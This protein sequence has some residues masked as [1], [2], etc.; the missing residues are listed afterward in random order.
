MKP[1]I[2]INIDD[3]DQVDALFDA[4]LRIRGERRLAEQTGSD[5]GKPIQAHID[6]LTNT[7]RQIRSA[8]DIHH[9]DEA[10]ADYERERN[11]GWSVR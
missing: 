10:Q 7:V 1:A 3:P 11:E 8:D 5:P 9:D 6:V 4:C 2:Y